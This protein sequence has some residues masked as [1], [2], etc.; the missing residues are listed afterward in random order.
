[1]TVKPFEETPFFRQEPDQFLASLVTM[2]N[3]DKTQFAI[4]VTVNGCVFS[5]TAIGIDEFIELVKKNLPKAEEATAASDEAQQQIPT[6]QTQTPRYLHLKDVRVITGSF[7][8]GYTDNPWRFLL[9]EV[10]G[11]ALTY[12]VIN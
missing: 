4:T 6:V 11:W 1:M 8:F 10:G 7:N 12:T 3:N 2:V 9:S 5:G